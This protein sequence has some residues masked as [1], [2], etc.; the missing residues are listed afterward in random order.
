VPDGHSNELELA[1][2][3]PFQIRPP[4][5]CKALVQIDPFHERPLGQMI[6]VDTQLV[7]FQV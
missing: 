1:Q 7:P 5:H 2:N 4:G 3:R 6:F